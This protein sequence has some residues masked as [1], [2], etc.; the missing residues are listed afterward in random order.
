MSQRSLIFSLTTH[1]R[2]VWTMEWLSE[3]FKAV[4]TSSFLLLCGRIYLL[5]SSL[6]VVSSAE[7]VN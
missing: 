3:V 2:I 6:P 4:R 1:D 5:S 7:K